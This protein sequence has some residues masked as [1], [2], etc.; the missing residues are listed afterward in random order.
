ETLSDF[1]KRLR[2]ERALTMMSHR[3]PTREPSLTQIALDCGFSSSSDFSRC[4]KQR[5]GASPSRFDIAGWQKRHRSAFEALVPGSE[6]EEGPRLDRLPG[7]GRTGGDN[8]D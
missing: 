6:G 2:L 1:V 5:Y 8:P 7:G 4:F 3:R